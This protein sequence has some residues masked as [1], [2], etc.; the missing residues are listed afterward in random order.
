MTST[1][2]SLALLSEYTNTL[3][4]LPIELARNFADLRE[5][6]AVMSAGMTSVSDKIQNLTDM[7][8]LGKGTKEERLWLLTDIADEASRLKAGGE[9][10]IRVAAQAADHLRAHANH[11]RALAECLPDFDAS[12]LIRHTTFPHVSA[13]SFGPVALLETGRRRRG[14]VGA[15]FAS[16]QDPSP[17][18]R[19]RNN[20][21]DD[22][23]D[24]RSPRKEKAEPGSR[25][26]Q[27]SRAKRAASPAES[28]LSVTSHRQNQNPVAN[29]RAGSRNGTSSNNKRA[30]STNNRPN[31]PHDQYA[32]YDPAQRNVFNVPPSTDHPSLP[33]PYHPPNGHPPYDLAAPNPLNGAEWSQPRQLEGPG[34]PVVRNPSNYDRLSPAAAIGGG[35]ATDGGATEGG[36]AE[37]EPDGDE[38]TYCFCGGISYGEMV[39]CD[40]KLCTREWFHIACVGMEVAPDG[41]WYCD[42]CRQRRSRGGNRSGRGTKKKAGTTRSGR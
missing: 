15:M 27:N 25:R 40:D 36:E 28:L 31:S 19:K 4:A 35:P 13:K 9:D 26:G 37:G 2:Y 18:K 1:P 7:I 20:A 39:A 29:S 22:D 11:L 32:M 5:L 33:I 42:S 6:D 17:V 16:L 41:T 14:N 34:M 12:K 30:R 38:K 24:V 23:A 10:K 21:R 8:E 3:D